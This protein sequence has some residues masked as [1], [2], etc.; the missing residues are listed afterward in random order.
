LLLGN[1][2]VVAG[3]HCVLNQP[4]QQHDQ[5]RPVTMMTMIS[6]LPLM[7]FRQN[8]K[9]EQLIRISYVGLNQW[10]NTALHSCKDP[11][12]LLHLALARGD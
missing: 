9:K 8:Q 12:D 1:S 7:I 6:V 10:Q 11:Q 4:C 2:F 5:F 3:E